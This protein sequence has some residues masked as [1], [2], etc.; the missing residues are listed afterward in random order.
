MWEIGPHPHLIPLARATLAG[1]AATGAGPAWI[2]TLRRDHADQ[3]Q[4]HAALAAHHDHTGADLDWAALHDGK[5]QRV[6]TL[7]T[8][9]F[10]RRRFWLPAEDRDHAT[11]STSDDTRRP[12]H[13]G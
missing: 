1:P 9:P 5:D 2:A 10:H 11:T 3:V 8:Y 7:P 4:L 12:E 13:H 6:T